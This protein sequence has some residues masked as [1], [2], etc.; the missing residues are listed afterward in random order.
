MKDDPQ[1][2]ATP[3]R[4]TVAIWWL[5]AALA[6]VAA[7]LLRLD[8]LAL[9]SLSHPEIYVPGIPL[10][11]GLSEPP[12]RLNLRDTLWFHYHDE[13]HPIGWYL[14]MFGWTTLAGAS[15]WALRFPGVVF[16]AA[17]VVVLFL[18]A[19][20]VYSARVAGLAAAMLALHGFHVH[21]S[22]AA[23][24]YV[25]GAFWG[26]VST[27]L[28]LVI[29]RAPSRRLWAEA[30]YVLATFAA[31]QTTELC[32]PLLFVQIAWAGLFVTPG[33]MP[34]L[35]D[36]LAF[37]PVALPRVLQVQS[38]ALM[39]AAPGLAH[40]VYRARKDAAEEP[41]L[42][43][44]Q[45]YFS[46]GFLYA[47]EP[48]A[49][50]E[51]RL[52][53][54]LALALLAGSVV[55]IL[56]GMRQ[57]QGRAAPTAATEPLPRW[58]APAL[59]VAT[60]AFVAWLAAIAHRRGV[61]LGV[62]ACLPLLA[63]ALPRLMLALRAILSTLS[64]A[65]DCWLGRRNPDVALLVLLAVALPLALFAASVKVSVLAARAFLVLVPYQLVLAAAGIAGGR[66]PVAVRGTLAVAVLAVFALSLPFNAPKP[67][68]PRD[69]KDIARQLRAALQPGDVVFL[70][71]RQWA[72]TPLLYYLGD[73]PV[74]TEDQA[75][76]V[77][78][79]AYPRVWLVTW[80]DDQGRVRTGVREEA[81]AGRPV[82]QE[83]TALRA[84]AALYLTGPGS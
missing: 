78:A 5:A 33:K 4:N 23:R 38:L 29:A 68:S 69:Y 19:R 30:G 70:R 63:L 9:K 18:L 77:A 58:L 81:L 32:L 43:F 66:G 74:V 47:H 61:Y 59:A 41:A 20:R 82:A 76:A 52:A 79:G 56:R 6:A 17:S 22:Q 8:D 54:P 51:I 1:R 57:G 37:R 39:L 50:P 46:F 44:L 11:Q 27:L 65:L 60:A 15:E 49:Q 34:P 3:R 67:V 2:P 75:A 35:R 55:L 10:P 64:P 31:L 53:L 48:F 16:A 73:V 40:A 80:P 28:L 13:P 71:A 62:I 84:R 83:L 42:P 14:M 36:I 26:L 45:E 72:D 7:V 21:W 12:P 25:P 24:M